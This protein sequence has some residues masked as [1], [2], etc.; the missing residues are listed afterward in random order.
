[1]KKIGIVGGIAWASTLDYYRGLCE[2]SE[3]RHAQRGERDPLPT[4]EMTIESL[5]LRT[6]VSYL[7]TIGDD[8]SWARFDAYHRSALKR[9][10]E[11]GA[12]VAVIASNTPHCRFKGIT[13]GLQIDVI[14]LFDVIAKHCKRHNL[15]R[16][17][18]F[19]TETTMH[20]PA[21]PQALARHG[22]LALIPEPAAQERIAAL[23]TRL[24]KGNIVGA[25]IDLHDIALRAGA[26]S[27]ATAVCL[28]CTELPHAFGAARFEPSF[29][30]RGI[31]FVNSAAVHIAAAFAAASG[32]N[33]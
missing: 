8:E 12:Q 6:A 13:S 10:Q 11:S 2:L 21:L 15:Q 16:A 33:E 30:S 19:G 23:I 5:D 29:L 27:P 28:C 31:T 4:P 1:M 3:R 24:Q 20:S 32:E 7:G 18:I 9:V 25:A 17:L 26:R 22:I 14:N